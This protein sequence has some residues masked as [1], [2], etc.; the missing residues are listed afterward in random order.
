MNA[1]QVVHKGEIFPSYTAL[2]T[3]YGVSPVTIRER[4]K[5]GVSG[6]KLV[7]RRSLLSPHS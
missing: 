1:K 6:D 2:A 3:R 4:L 7:C 5:R